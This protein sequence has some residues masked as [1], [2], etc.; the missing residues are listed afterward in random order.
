M[1]PIRGGVV[2]AIIS[3]SLA[4][5]GM[6]AIPNEAS[7]TPATISL[8]PVHCSYRHHGAYLL[9]DPRC[10]PGSR[11][12]RVTPS[13][14]ARTIC[15]SG[16][17]KGVRPPTSY[18]TPLKRKL[19]VVYGA[20]GPM[21]AYELDHEIP[22]EGGGAPLAVSN[23]WPE[24]IAQARVKDRVENTIRKRACANPRTLRTLQ[25]KVATDWTTLLP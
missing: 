5:C 14:V 4:G 1:R 18:T 21:N 24:P 20:T 25:A 11:N 2:I 12:P 3:A 17:T 16:Y 19:M 15:V 7:S 10:T 23:L 13:T 8:V 22:L 6:T 9:P